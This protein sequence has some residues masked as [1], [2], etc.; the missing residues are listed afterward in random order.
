MED[1]IIEEIIRS[2]PEYSI[3]K[4]PFSLIFSGA[5]ITISFGVWFAR[6]MQLKILNWEKENISPLPLKNAYT[7]ISWSGGFMGL[8]LFFCGMLQVFDFGSIKSLIA[9]LI[10][11]LFSGTT[12]WGVIKDLLDQMDSGEIKEIDEY[13]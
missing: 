10:V 3:L 7:V 12:M 6:L 5:L 9:S 11:S 4:D 1:Q 13:F 8:S 2:Y